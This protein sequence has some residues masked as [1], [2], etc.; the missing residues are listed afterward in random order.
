MTSTTAPTLSRISRSGSLL[1]ARELGIAIV[2]VIVFGLTTLH[3]HSFASEHSVQQLLAGAAL[4]AL[5]GVGEAIV[6]AMS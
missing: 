5:L 6:T 4:V 3:N 2:I 1:R